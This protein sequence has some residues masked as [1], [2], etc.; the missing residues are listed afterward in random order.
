[1]TL[2]NIVLA[3]CLSVLV[4]GTAQAARNDL[5]PQ[6]VSLDQRVSQLERVVDNDAL[7]EILTRL[8]EI[9]SEVAAL[10][11]DVEQLQFEAEQGGKR[12]RDLYL[13]VDQRLQAL[14]T[15][16]ASTQAA[17][18]AAIAGG[19]AAGV[20]AGTDAPAAQLPVPGGTA[21]ENY[22]AAYKLVKQKRYDEA[23]VAFRQFVVAFPDSGLHSNALFWEGQS[24]YMLGRYDEALVAFQKVLNDFPDA[25]KVP[26]TLLKIGFTYYELANWSQARKAL[27]AVMNRFPETTPARLASQRLATMDQEGH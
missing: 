8:D 23:A 10:R 9:Q 7:V 25:R 18:S 27:N 15:A 26:E 24:F 17:S 11:S 13:D 6:V 16:A 12:Q 22:D 20:A 5:Y 2:N 14:E 19:A 3:S 4:A 21:Q 1:M